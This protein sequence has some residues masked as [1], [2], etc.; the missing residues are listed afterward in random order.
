MTHP[1]EVIREGIEVPIGQPIANTTAHVLDPYMQPTPFGVVGELYI[2]GPGVA[3]GYHARPSLTAERFVPDPFAAIPGAR[4]YRTGDLVRRLSSGDIEFV[5]RSDRQIKLRGFR[6]ELG[7]IQAVLESEPGVAA[8]AVVLREDRAGDRRLAAYVVPSAEQPEPSASESLATERVGAWE[9]WYDDTYGRSEQ[10]DAKFDT[11]GWTSTFTGEAIPSADM[12]HWLDVT[13]AR[14]REQAPR[15]VLEIG[16]GTGM[17]LFE[18]A[19]MAERYVGLDISSVVLDRLARSVAERGLRGVELQQATADDLSFVRGQQFDLVILNSVVQYF[20]SVEYL[21]EVIERAIDLLAPQGRLFLGDLRNLWL[22]DAFHAAVELTRADDAETRSSFARRMPGQ[23]LGDEEL[24]LSPA[25]F[26]A[27]RRRFSRIG[28]VQI[29]I[30]RGSYDNELT[31]YRYDVTLHMDDRLPAIPG[32][33][34]HERNG[35]LSVAELEQ[36]LASTDAELIVLRELPN[37]RVADDMKILAW[38]EDESG[39]SNVGGLHEVMG[40]TMVASLH[41][42]TA[43]AIAEAHAFVALRELVA[44]ATGVL[45][46]RVAAG[47]ERGNTCGRT[48]ALGLLA[49][50][51]R[52]RQARQPTTASTTLPRAR[53]ATAPEREREAAG[54]HGAG[55]RDGADQL[56]VERKRQGRRVRAACPRGSAAAARGRL[57]AAVELARAAFVRIVQ[58]GPARRSRRH[59]GRLLRARW[60]LRCWPRR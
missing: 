41:P 32:D 7:E 22:L 29:Q 31:R 10:E 19:P 38:L 36:L 5:G 34:V 23:I 11:T 48:A 56:A 46:P 8:C 30:K 21:L 6:I 51:A 40:R 59:R 9:S 42:E 24:V 12:R 39:P 13:A 17:I 50:G 28:D 33:R 44:H 49:A 26:P 16:C 27:L 37:P 60:S 25:L 3:R 55:E 2:G 45:R 52:S 47:V 15:R 4:M 14:I 54:L 57:R 58:R 18:V 35:A 20:P 53:P 1:I 43:C